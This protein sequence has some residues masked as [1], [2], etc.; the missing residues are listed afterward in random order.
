MTN[1]QSIGAPVGTSK[2]HGAASKI[3]LN[4][5]IDAFVAV[6]AGS[7]TVGV[8]VLV[9]LQL[10]SSKARAKMLRIIFAFICLPYSFLGQV[11]FGITLAYSIDQLLESS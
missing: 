9:G 5:W 6:G 4:S 8:E 7:E 11:F 1:P 3:A 10:A 2:G